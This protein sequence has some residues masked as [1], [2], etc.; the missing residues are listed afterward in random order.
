[1]AGVDGYIGECGC[2]LIAYTERPV[3]SHDVL[4]MYWHNFNIK[5]A[6]N[7]LNCVSVAESTV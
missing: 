4:K 2:S 6:N 3:A 5:E 7:N 1:M